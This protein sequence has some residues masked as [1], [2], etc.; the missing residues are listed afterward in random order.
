[1]KHKHEDLKL[2]A[3]RFYLNT[4]KPFKEIGRIFGVDRR[5]LKR[6]IDRYEEENE[7]KRH[8]RPP[9]SYKVRRPHIQFALNELRRNEQITMFELDKKIR[10]RFND[11]DCVPQ[12]L[13]RVIR[14]HNK[15]RKRTRL[16][17]FP[18]TRY[19]QPVDKQ[20][21]FDRFYNKIDEYDL[22]KIICMDETSIPLGL[23]PDY[24]RCNLGKRC[25]LKTDD[26]A[27]FKKY[28][29][30]SAISS[31]GLV[32]YTLY[33]QGGMNTERMVEFLNQYIVG[34]YRDCLIVMDNAGAHKK[35][36]I[37]TTITNSRNELLYTPPYTPRANAVENWF[38]QFKH[39]LK[40]DGVL[41]FNALRTSVRTAITKIRP[42][43]YLN[44]FRFAYRKEELRQHEQKLSTLYHKPKVYK[45]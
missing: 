27:V 2:S 11:Y 6:W 26:N 20:A 37:R 23:A 41:T 13:G 4:R 15:T 33:E 44:Y 38:S 17:H 16:E 28:T 12:H 9:V 10:E 45:A 7:I 32:G 8:N 36:E 24:S 5:S 14:D 31:T 25:V 1:M 30:L 39:Y 29:L 34:R 18:A 42:E 19:G 3:V 40:K 43:N 21:E 22:N 35:P